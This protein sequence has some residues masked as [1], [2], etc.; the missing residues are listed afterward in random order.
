MQP[1]CPKSR[2]FLFLLLTF[3]TSAPYA[4]AQEEPAELVTDRPD[5]TESPIVVPPGSVQIE[6]GA[7]YTAD[8]EDAVDYLSTLLRVGLTRRLELRL[9]TAGWNKVLE[10]D[11]SPNFGDAELG[12]KVRLWDENGWRPEAALLLS[13]SI[14]IG[15]DTV[16]T[17][18]PDPAFR[19]SFAHT[20]TERLSLGYNVGMAWETTQAAPTRYIRLSTTA[21]QFS[22]LER[23]APEHTLAKLEYTASLGIGITDRLG[24]FIEVYG[25]TPLNA[26]S[27]TAHA[28]DGGFTYLL[29][30]NVQLDISGGVGLNDAADDWF[31]GA[32]L[33]FR[34]PR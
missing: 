25:D 3:L 16:S 11:E 18:S 9:A 13:T 17:N 21:P 32:G 20:L 28:L 4:T 7:A 22:I 26:H 12:A 33:S 27:D 6:T 19:F 5:Q 10:E 2:L 24:A 29:R 31:V 14:P 1:N 34:L 30:P 15:S 8:E 23:E